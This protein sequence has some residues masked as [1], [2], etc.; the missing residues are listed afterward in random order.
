VRIDAVFTFIA[1]ADRTTVRV[2]FDLQRGGLPPGTLAPVRWAIADKVRDIIGHDL[3]D[4]KKFIEGRSPGAGTIARAP[5][6]PLTDDDSR[7]G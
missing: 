1:T 2:E 6:A 4:L 3:A 7:G 5:V